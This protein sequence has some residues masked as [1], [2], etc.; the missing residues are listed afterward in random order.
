MSDSGDIL[1]V[2]LMGSSL[3]WTEDEREREEVGYLQ[4]LGP[5][6]LEEWS[7]HSLRLVKTGRSGFEEGVGI[8]NSGL[9]IL[10]LRCLLN[11]N[12]EI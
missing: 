11:L 10:S 6:L 5:E 12:R 3:G 2:K 8:M 9:Y 7:C 4:G 1:R